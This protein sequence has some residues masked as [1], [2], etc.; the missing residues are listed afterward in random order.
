MQ[1]YEINL[2]S[3]QTFIRVAKECILKPTP[4]FFVYL[5][6]VI[7]TLYVYLMVKKIVSFFKTFVF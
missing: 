3:G 4:L 2:K 6:I 5:E 1:D 7:Q